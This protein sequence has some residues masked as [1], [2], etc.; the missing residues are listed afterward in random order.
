[1]DD[2]RVREKMT[3]FAGGFPCLRNAVGVNPWD[4]EDL[5]R[6]AAGPV[7]HGERVTAQFLLAVWSPEDEWRSGRFDLMEAL[8]LWDPLHHRAFLK[9]AAEPWWP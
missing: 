9:W 1:M 3:A 4:A 8:R 2:D 6:W 7:S 5:D